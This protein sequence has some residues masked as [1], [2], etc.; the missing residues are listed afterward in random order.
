METIV[1]TR[2][3]IGRQWFVQFGEDMRC[4]LAPLKRLGIKHFSNVRGYN[5]GSKTIL[6]THPGFTILFFNHRFHQYAFSAKP[7]KYQQ[8]V[9]LIEDLI[10]AAPEK[11]IILTIR[12]ACIQHDNFQPDLMFVEKG[13]DYVDFFF[14][15]AERNKK[16]M[17]TFYL[18]HLSLF[19]QYLKFFKQYAHNLLKKSQETRFLYEDKLG[20]STPL[21]S[22]DFQEQFNILGKNTDILDNKWGGNSTFVFTK[23]ELLIACYLQAGFSSK[24]IATK[25][26]IS[27]RTVEKHILNLR[28]KTQS[29][30]IVHLIAQLNELSWLR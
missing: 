24:E 26:S 27:P 21:V 14:F 12:E 29:R 1:L 2:Q 7:Q 4:L 11:N 17:A 6:T 28:L 19:D 30:N 18:T 15:G 25:I 8:G 23:K 16:H 20:D 10:K 5:D 22:K 3:N 9:V 13:N